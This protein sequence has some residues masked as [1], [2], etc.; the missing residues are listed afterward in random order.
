MLRRN[1]HIGF[2]ITILGYGQTASGKSHTIGSEL[3]NME[4]KEHW[5]LLPRMLH[6]I[7]QKTQDNEATMHVS[8][9]EIYGE[10]IHD[11]LLPIMATNNDGRK[12]A[13]KQTLQLRQDRSGV[14]VQGIREVSIYIYMI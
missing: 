14:F 6:E 12:H 13:P 11:L 7:F 4:E 2:N 8:F 9:L 1:L 3:N 5:G 10:D